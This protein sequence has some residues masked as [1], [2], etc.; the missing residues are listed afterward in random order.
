MTIREY[1]A[2]HPGRVS[3][4]KET[5]LVFLIRAGQ[6]LLAMKKRGFGVGRWNGVGG[7]LQAGETM[8]A[9]ARRE[10]AEEIG[11]VPGGMRRVA[12][13]QFYFAPDAG[14]DL[15]NIGCDVFICEEWSGQPSESEEMAP[16][17]YPQDALPFGDM[18]PDDPHW[19]PLVLAGKQV[20]AEFLF[21]HGDVIL[22]QRVEAV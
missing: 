6:V 12:R 20:E 1:H 15:Q 3:R 7:K 22:D 8:E 21:G 14:D 5:N 18:W 4:L 11:V 9:S 10:T 17:W 13:L 2:A 19:L 16:A